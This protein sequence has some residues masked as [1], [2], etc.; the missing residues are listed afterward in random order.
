[1]KLL[2]AISTKLAAVTIVLG[3]LVGVTCYNALSVFRDVSG[4][5]ADI[6]DETIPLL[7]S[8]F[9]SS[10]S[11]NEIN[12]GLLELVLAKDNAQL[13]TASEHAQNGLSHLSADSDETGEVNQINKLLKRAVAARALEFDTAISLDKKVQALNVSIHAL[14]AEVR[15][16][17]DTVFDQASTST[18]DLGIAVAE[19]IDRLVHTEATAIRVALQTKSEFNRA[20]GFALAFHHADDDAVKNI[21]RDLATTSLIRLERTMPRIQ[22]YELTAPAYPAVAK[23]V[24]EISQL[25]E[26][27]GR[28]TASDT[29]GEFDATDIALAEA[30]DDALYSLAIFGEDMLERTGMRLVVTLPEQMIMLDQLGEVDSAIVRYLA[31]VLGTLDSENIEAAAQSQISLEAA[32]V[33]LENAVGE[34]PGVELANLP[35]AM[36]AVDPQD[37][38][39]ATKIAY[40]DASEASAIAAREAFTAIQKLSL[41]TARNGEAILS[42]T[43]QEID[44]L[45]SGVS[46]ARQ[47]MI[48]I[49]IGSAVLFVLS[50]V[51]VYLMISRPVRT[52]TNQTKRLASGDTS[53]IDDLK[54]H[55]GEIAELNAALRVFRQGQ[56]DRSRMEEEAR[57][58]E[59]RQRQAE[60]DAEE[61]QRKLEKENRHREGQ[62]AEEKRRL[63]EEARAAQEQSRQAAEEERQRLM[64]R[65]QSV[66]VSL[67]SG[68]SELAKGNLG[69]SIDIV[70]PEEYER[71]RADFNGAINSLSDAMAQ[72]V[73]ISSDV[74]FESRSIATAIEAVTQRSETSAATLEE[75]SAALEELT[76]SVRS[77]AEAARSA[78]TLASETSR[79]AEEGGAIVGETKAAMQRIEDSSS[80]VARITGVID[81]IAFQTNL[82]A[83]NAGVEAAR[84][85][86]AGRGFAVVAS[87]VRSLAQRASDSAREIRDLISSSEED[88]SH[89][90]SLVAATGV[91]LEKMVH[92][93]QQIASQ[94]S[95]ISTSA[96]EQSTT[97]SEMNTS[98]SNLDGTTQKNAAMFSD[99]RD[100]TQV[101]AAR[102]VELTGAVSRFETRRTDSLTRREPKAKVPP[103]PP[104]TSAQYTKRRASANSAIAVGERLNVHN[105]D[106]ED[107]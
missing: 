74:D 73:A 30:I 87:E 50:Q 14:A 51:V 23:A 101:L 105:E 80:K 25:V 2:G 69:Y 81:D 22:E 97:V 85:G 53:E 19:D 38:L 6:S 79:L 27:S 55:G 63:E 71:L 12:S 64:D 77:A 94:V 15:Q 90:V 9:S 68:L 44:Q 103:E 58:A 48:A 70:F 35:A 17:G 52:I 99:T 104:R 67:A 21:F 95:Q 33:E 65:Q 20:A 84:A 42:E 40:F 29:L 82:L 26:L 24:A 34:L 7:K 47:T 16:I 96:S 3:G 102:A 57:V 91:S 100:A 31:A 86:E 59:A 61:Q 32:A 98:I 39:V 36:A 60:K 46:D 54:V 66:V 62:A 92:S 10:S 13:S 107:F 89:G 106:W 88:V 56:I 28:S 8:G 5:T 45:A 1:M 18:S 93:I 4:L 37:G 43:D 11:V 72:I 78:D 75:S 49:A 83:L 76:A 41:A